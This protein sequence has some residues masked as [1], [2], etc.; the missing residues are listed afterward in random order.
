MFRMAVGHS[1]DVDLDQV[2]R[3]LFASTDAQLDGAHP[4]A[5]LLLSS[6]DQDHANLVAAVR[7]HYP[8]MALAGSTTAG[9]MTSVLG[10]LEDSVAL[11]VF[12]SDTVEVTAGLGR[13]LREDP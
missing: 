6:W 4:V 13:R 3:E 1:G 11:A 12:A 8:T 2:L 9:E 5:G 7:E 10:F